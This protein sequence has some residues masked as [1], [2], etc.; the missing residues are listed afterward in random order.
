MVS[1]VG[2]GIGGA[3]LLLTLL[4]LAV[5]CY[6]CGERKASSRRDEEHSED[7]TSVSLLGKNVSWK[8]DF[9]S[10]LDEE[11]LMVMK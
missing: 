6:F 11:L 8:C 9:Y 2:A 1:V 4:T 10:C 5:A 3:V 7:F